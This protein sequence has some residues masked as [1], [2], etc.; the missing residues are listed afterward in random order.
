MG[1]AQFDRFIMASRPWGYWLADDPSGALRD[2]S[3]NG[4]D[5]SATGSPIY[6]S[7]VGF[8]AYGVRLQ[9]GSSFATSVSLS[10]S[11]VAGWTVVALLRPYAFASGS[12]YRN[13]FV[14][15]GGDD[16]GLQFG[17][18][19]NVGNTA[20]L[21][22]FNQNASVAYAEAQ[23]SQIR[24]AGESM[25]VSGFWDGATVGVQQR[26]LSTG[27]A[28]SA[29]THGDSGTIQMIAENSTSDYVIGRIAVF[30]SY[31]GQGAIR[32]LNNA[33]VS[34]SAAGQAA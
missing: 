2:R 20:K 6:R 21:L 18:G 19:S 29:S 25:F 8:G 28:S 24:V 1:L 13:R 34:R 7:P 12:P 23:D 31:I 9:S 22:A 26:G 15:H 16:F 14:Y 27:S 30:T 3:G 17:Y 10:M 32:R 33:L 4:R 5:M 11:G